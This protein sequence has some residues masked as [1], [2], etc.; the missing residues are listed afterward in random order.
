[1]PY[2]FAILHKETNDI[3]ISNTDSSKIFTKSPF[4]ISISCIENPHP[5]ILAL[6]INIEPELILN[7]IRTW[8][9]ILILLTL[10]ILIAFIRTV[11]HLRNEQ[12][13]TREKMDFVNNMTHEY[14]TPLA[15][16][17]M[18]S[19]ILL[20]EYRNHDDPKLLR[21]LKIIKDENN[22]LRQFSERMMGMTVID[23]DEITLSKENLDTHTIF[24]KAA[25][26][27][28]LQI[29]QA[30]A[31][32]NMNLKAQKSTIYGDPVHMINVFINILDN[33]I[34]YAG[35]QPRINIKTSNTEE[36]RICIQICDNGTGIPYEQQKHIF[37][38]FYRGNNAKSKK[39]SGFGLGLFYVKK[40]I[41]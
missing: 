37:N 7:K 26:S 15:T 38:Q 33:A 22:R 13:I 11:M 1:M 35:T 34:K 41:Q 20:Q 21:Y 28:K 18:S 4:T 36:N 5:Y 14:K 6:N 8:L 10:L 31:E 2:R 39:D 9:I 24:K 17:N 30:N 12:R 29:E 23:R 3:L 19:D 25:E 16:I 27:L 40:I 32:L